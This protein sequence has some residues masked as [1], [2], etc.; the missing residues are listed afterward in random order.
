MLSEIERLMSGKWTPDAQVEI[1]LKQPTQMPADDA[2]IL[3]GS[4]AYIILWSNAKREAYVLPR[5]TVEMIRGRPGGVKST[6]S[7]RT[8]TP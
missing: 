1:R 4:A 8:A 3:T 5:D 6:D 2:T 7:H